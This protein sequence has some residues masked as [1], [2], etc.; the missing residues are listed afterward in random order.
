[1][2]K[3]Y[4][5]IMLAVLVDKTEEEKKRIDDL[6]SYEMDWVEIAGILM[7]HRLGGYFYFGL[8]EKQRHIIP[9]ELRKNLNMLIKGQ[10]C[11]QK[12]LCKYISELFD[13]LENQD[14]RYAGLKGIVFGA[15]IYSIGMRRSNDLDL[16]VYEEDLDKLDKL[17][18][19]I[20][21]IQGSKKDGALVEATKKE[22][23]IQR[24]NYHDLVPYV[25]ET[26][27]R[28][29]EID[30]NFLID[31]KENLID[32]KVFEIGTCI[33]EG[34]CYKFRGLKT[35]TNFAFLI[36]HFYRE[37]TGELWVNNKRNLLLYKIVDIVNYMRRFEDQLDVISV[38][39][40]LDELN[41]LE[42][43]LYTFLTIKQFYG[44]EKT[45]N[46]CIEK[47]SVDYSDLYQNYYQDGIFEQY[48]EDSYNLGR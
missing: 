43:A 28:V 7:N 44:H 22:K 20:G 13:T 36:C 42:K 29:I 47:I 5:L 39:K 41:L 40:L 45:I 3:E 23:L 15:T 2:K 32:D 17:M 16:L 48:Y 38:V 21:Y 9:K 19:K 37:A 10:A 46:E 8:S 18:R 26:E 11:E 31:G 4:E 25:K 6:L 12:T 24:M 1:M 35:I 33:Y 34:E 27:D 14:L 30:I